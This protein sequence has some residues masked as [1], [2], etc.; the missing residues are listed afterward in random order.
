MHYP[1]NRIIHS[2]VFAY[3]IREAHVGRPNE[4]ITIGLSK[5][6]IRNVLPVR[7]LMQNKLCCRKGIVH[8]AADSFG[9]VRLNM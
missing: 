4:C 1:T 2:T 6:V 8:I 5:S 7:Q 9:G 3:T